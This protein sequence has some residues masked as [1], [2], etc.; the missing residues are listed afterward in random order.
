MRSSVIL[1]LSFYCLGLKGQSDLATVEQNMRVQE[2]AWNAGNLEGF[3][4]HY[5]KSDSLTFIG[6]N[7]V[8]YGWTQTLANYKKSYPSAEAMGILKF[9]VIGRL[10]VS[11]DAIYIIGK[12]ALQ[13]QKPA[14]GH[15]TLLWRKIN[16]QW[17]ITSDHTS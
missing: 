10:Q 6:K 9:T 17:V 15:F 7:G 1:L 8:T 2:D 4:A 13:K 14:E 12:W 5:W 16:R 3:M 11:P